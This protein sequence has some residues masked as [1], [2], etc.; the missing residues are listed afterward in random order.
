MEREATPRVRAARPRRSQLR[1]D[2]LVARA[3]EIRARAAEPGTGSRRPKGPAPP[4]P[5]ITATPMPPRPATVTG[6]AAS[7]D[8]RWGDELNVALMRRA[9][10]AARAAGRLRAGA[11]RPA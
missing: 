7:T 2:S 10:S 5:L 9:L 6:A 11:R 8:S 3:A 1:R 4:G